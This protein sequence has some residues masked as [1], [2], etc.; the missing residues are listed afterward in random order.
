MHVKDTTP[1][2][3]R[4]HPGGPKFICLVCTKELVRIREALKSSTARE[5]SAQGTIYRDGSFR[6]TNI[7]E[8]TTITEL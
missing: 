8:I 5:R 6:Q 7:A 4:L 1:C 2:H 3:V